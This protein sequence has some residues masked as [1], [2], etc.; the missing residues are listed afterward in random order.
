MNKKVK[1]ILESAGITFVATFLLVV[2]LEIGQDNFV[3]SQ[4]SLL[5]LVISGLVASTRA[6]ARIIYNIVKEYVKK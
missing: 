2:S 5:A 1:E 6:V 3:F 4:D